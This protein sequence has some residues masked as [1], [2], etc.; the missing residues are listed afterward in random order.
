MS[1]RF[2]STRSTVPPGGVWF[3][4][5]GDDHYE[6]PLYEDALKHVDMILKKHGSDADAVEALADYMCPHLPAY[7][8]RGEGPSTASVTP[9][10]AKAAAIEYFNRSV[11]TL[12]VISRRMQA[13]TTCPKHRR[14]FCLHCNGYD[15]WIYDGFGGRRVRL[16]ADDASGCC[17][18]AK[19]FEAV[20]ATAMYNPGEAVWE[21]APDTCWRKQL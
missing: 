20:I 2:V 16:P 8:C 12:D 21:G 18:C 13:C 19:T 11:E 9:H 17:E 4:S 5:M 3:F 14:D 7:F 1:R 15:Q 10:E 6:S